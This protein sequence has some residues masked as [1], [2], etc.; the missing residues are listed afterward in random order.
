MKFDRVL[1]LKVSPSEK[2]IIEQMRTMANQICDNVSCP[3][4]PFNIVIDED[5]NITGCGKECFN[6]LEDMIRED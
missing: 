4:C 3:E 5:N 6:Q 2:V 1:C